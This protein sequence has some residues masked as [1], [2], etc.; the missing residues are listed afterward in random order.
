MTTSEARVVRQ[1][2]GDN[3]FA[4]LASVTFQH[5]HDLP[6]LEVPDVDLHVFTSAHDMFPSRRKVREYAKCAIRMPAVR[7]DTLGRLGVP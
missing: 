5:L 2:R 6:R 1:L 4:Q 3:K 7:L